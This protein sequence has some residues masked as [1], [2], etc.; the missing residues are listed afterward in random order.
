MGDVSRVQISAMS[1]QMENQNNEII[2]N[3]AEIRKE[4]IRVSKTLS[5]LSENLGRKLRWSEYSSQNG[6]RIG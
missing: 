6:N 2:Y 5:D 3:L 4:I 1:K